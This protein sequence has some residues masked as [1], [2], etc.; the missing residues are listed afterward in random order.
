MLYNFKDYIYKTC[1]SRLKKSHSP[2]QAGNCLY[3]FLSYLKLERISWQHIFFEKVATMPKCQFSNLK[4][5]V[6]KIPQNCS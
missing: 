3:K 6:C 2:G 5:V 4:G 1:R